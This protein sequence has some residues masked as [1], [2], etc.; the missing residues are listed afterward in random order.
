MSG[1]ALHY[2]CRSG[3]AVPPLFCVH[4]VCM[5][6]HVMLFCSS[7]HSSQLCYALEVEDWI[8]TGMDD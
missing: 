3:S 6:M 5:R 1:G 4:D 2:A 8:W 7:V